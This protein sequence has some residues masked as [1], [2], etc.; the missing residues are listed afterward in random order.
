M[1]ELKEANDN[2][3]LYAK[4]AEEARIAESL[5]RRK[6]ANV[7]IAEGPTLEKLPSKPNFGLNFAVGFLVAT[8]VS[9]GSPFVVEGLRETVHI[10]EELE[11]ATGLRALAS[12]P[13]APQWNTSTRSLS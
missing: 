5:D 13:S 8:L 7:A 9:F 12:V 11:V 1:R 4:K 2:Y 6:I 10:P 3:L